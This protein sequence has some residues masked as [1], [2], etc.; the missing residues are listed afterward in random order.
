[1]A[2]KNKGSRRPRTGRADYALNQK[3][4]VMADRRTKRRRTRGASKRKAIREQLR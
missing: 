1:M 2:R 3:R 4:Q